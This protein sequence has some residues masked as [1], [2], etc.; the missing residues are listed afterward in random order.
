MKILAAVTS[1]MTRSLLSA[2]ALLAFAGCGGE[3]G[4]PAQS[5]SSTAAGTSTSTAVSTTT[6]T[7]LPPIGSTLTSVQLASTANTSQ[8]DVPLTFGQ[9]FAK[10]HFPAG[11]GLTGVLAGGTQIPLQ[12][13]VKA[14]HNDGS[15]RHAIISTRVPQL[16]AGQTRTLNL[17]STTTPPDTA[18]GITPAALLAAGFTASVNVNING[19][20]YSASADTL[21]AN[22]GY[23]TWLSG[24]LA[25]EWLV[26]AP[27]KT[28][29]G[30]EH[31]H[32]AARFAIRAYA[33]AIRARV[34]VTIENNW[35]YE[36]DPRNF[37]YDVQVLV[38]GQS[39]YQKTGLTHYHHAR[40]RKL[41]WWGSEP[42]IHV[43][44]D[45]AYLIAS[46][47][48][49]NYDPGITISPTALNS[50]AADWNSQDTGPMDAGIV[51][52]YMPTTG[53]RPDIGPLP[54]WAA[55]YLLSMDWRAKNIT[56]GVGD[57]AGSWPI[58]Y[59]DKVT[60]LPVSIADYPYSR[61]F[62]ISSDSYNP[63]TRQNES[64]PVCTASG[65]CTTPYSP[66][67]AHQP[68]MAYVPYLTTG[69][70]YYLEELHFWANWNLINA[71]PYYRGFSRGL[72]R[73]DQV[74]GQAWSLRTLGHAAYITPDAHPM[75]PYF[76]QIVA[77]NLDFYHQTYVVGN[78]NQF[79]AIDGSG[80]YAFNPFGYTTPAGPSTGIAPW[81]DDFF[82]WSIG[83]LA[84]LDFS[85]AQPILTWKAKFPVGRMTAPGFCWIDGGAYTLTL[86][87]S[88]NAVLYTSFAEVYQ[89]S[90]RAAD[91][92]ALT[93]S[94]GGRFLDQACN[95]QAQADWRTQYDRDTSTARVPWVVGEMTG[96][97]T[98]AAGF[99]SNMQPALAVAATTGIPNAQLAWSIFI[100][101]T[102]KPNYANEPQWAIVPR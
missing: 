50:L 53:G 85:A 68:S 26:S 45:R 14:S 73:S 55:M 38:G 21:L 61:T 81:Q 12:V 83:Y 47:A 9:V 94:L 28:A 46:K 40:W 91:G 75:K 42:E 60:G 90:M 74:R 58:H 78:P 65:A 16:N 24:P 52:P 25:T 77:D 64:L 87:P 4:A 101:R 51:L 39:A 36:A 22:G 93:N 82:T 49:P 34:D 23:A 63:V 56:L 20:A 95:S 88:A 80:Q 7:T 76:M 86:R 8:N 18:A 44:H 3:A 5:T 29:G 17:A 37:T 96:Y 84:E 62:S 48:I 54:M 11:A 43:G 92:S 72:V 35:A 98:S 97:A 67:A 41:F 99:P 13:N 70:Y 15:V 32:L 57:L 79:G 6:T 30:A 66:D 59:R 33:G 1:T 19:Q 89:S 27:L 71:H 102:V 31:P 10:G 69:D 2:L 100:N